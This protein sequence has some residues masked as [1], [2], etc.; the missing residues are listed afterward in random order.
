MGWDGTSPNILM[1]LHVEDIP[2]TRATVAR[3]QHRIMP[4]NDARMLIISWNACVWV[5][6][7]DC[8]H[9]PYIIWCFSALLWM[10]E[11]QLDWAWMTT[12]P[13]QPWI[14]TW[15]ND[16]NIILLAFPQNM[17]KDKLENRQ[18]LQPIILHNKTEFP[19]RTFIDQQQKEFHIVPYQ[20]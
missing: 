14:L 4:Y 3:I 9:R 6:V 15:R 2:D 5:F 18:L 12:V 1:A 10:G 16:S 13:V 20:P 7:V 8:S 19:S 11:F 17:F